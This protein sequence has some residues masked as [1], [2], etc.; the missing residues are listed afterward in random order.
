MS[1]TLTKHEAALA[2]LEEVLLAARQAAV[3]AHAKEHNDRFQSG[4]KTAYYDVLTV[5]L[6]QAELF[7]LNP[8]EFGMADFDP[9]SLLGAPR[10][11][12]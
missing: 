1:E 12:A 2:V 6:E 5:A 11:A 8:V 10:K 4:L 7:E 9:D 3:K